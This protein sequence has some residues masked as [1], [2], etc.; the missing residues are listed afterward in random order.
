MDQGDKFK[1]ILCAHWK[2]VSFFQ[3][4]IEFREE[5][6]NPLHPYSSLSS[7]SSQGFWSRFNQQQSCYR[8]GLNLI[9]YIGFLGRV[10]YSKSR[11]F[12]TYRNMWCKAFAKSPELYN[13]IPGWWVPY[14]HFRGFRR[15]DWRPSAATPY[16]IRAWKAAP[17]AQIK[18]EQDLNPH[19]K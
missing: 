2:S 6:F 9:E 5:V 18:S 14:V 7:A 1:L 16:F 3:G 11:F 17:L 15:K 8:P 13:Y 12:K 4:L 19:I 10:N